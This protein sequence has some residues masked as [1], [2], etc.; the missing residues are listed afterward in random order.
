[1]SD[2]AAHLALAVAAA[3]AGLALA[4]ALA[5]LAHRGLGEA[6]VILPS[7][8]WLRPLAAVV[9]GVCAGAVGPQWDLVAWMIFAAAAVT[10]TLTDCAT[11]R[12]PNVLVGGFTLL[13]VAA[14]GMAAWVTAEPARFISALLT[15]L[16]VFVLFAALALVHPRGLGFGDVK[17][18][19]PI[20]LYL[21]WLGWPAV[22]FG[23]GAAFALGAI[24]A[25]TVAVVRRSGRETAIPFGPY[26]L[27]GV[28]V[29][30]LVATA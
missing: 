12:L 15:G 10:L 9:F 28:G 6:T 22:V 19:A 20:G 5:R 29:C 25:V 30:L 26:L 8:G 14:L 21:G 24:A 27:A 1:M 11:H 23:V 7:P 17:L 2:P 13:G 3:L 16:G 4:P 18:A